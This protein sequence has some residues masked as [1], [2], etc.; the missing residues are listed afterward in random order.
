[1]SIDMMAAAR[2]LSD[3]GANREPD[4]PVDIPMSQGQKVEDRF[5]GQILEWD[6]REEAVI[7]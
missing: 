2:Q 5:P 4:A 7:F 6:K 1:M 3:A